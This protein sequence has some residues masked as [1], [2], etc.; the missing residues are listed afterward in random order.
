MAGALVGLLE[1]WVLNIDY[2]EIYRVVSRAT[3][4]ESHW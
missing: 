2:F 1:P 3:D 4:L